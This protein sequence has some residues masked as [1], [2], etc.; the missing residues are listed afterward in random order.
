MS[1]GE[2]TYLLPDDV[3]Y[4]VLMT[5]MVFLV[6]L[7]HIAARPEFF[8][9]RDSFTLKDGMKPLMTIPPEAVL[10]QFV[11]RAGQTDTPSMRSL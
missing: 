11:E 2:Q 1:K 8:V 4:G 7:F 9:S 6:T 3:V 10:V 5:K